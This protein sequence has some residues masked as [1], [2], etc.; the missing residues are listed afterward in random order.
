MK[1]ILLLCLFS[2]PAWADVQEKFSYIVVNSNNAVIFQTT[3]PILVGSPNQATD[4]AKAAQDLAKYLASNPSNFSTRITNTATGNYFDQSSNGTGTCSSST[5]QILGSD[6]SCLSVTPTAPL[7]ATSMASTSSSSK[8]MDVVSN[9]VMAPATQTRSQREHQKDRP[10]QQFILAV[11]DLKYE[12]AEFMNTNNKGNIGGFSASGSYDISK[13]WT[14]GVVVPY[15]HM[16]FNTFDAD[17]TGT[18]LYVKNTLKLPS[19]FELSTAVNGNYIYTSTQFQAQFPAP[20]ATT[21]LNTFGGGFSTRLKFDRLENNFIPAA[22]FSWQYNQ[23]NSGAVDN[24]QYL[25]KFG[26][27]LGYRLLDNATIQVSGNW[28]SDL[29]QYQQLQRGINYYDVGLEGAWIISDTWQLRGGYKKILGLTNYS[30]D[31]FYLGSNYKF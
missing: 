2:S 28:S 11:A 26:P 21:A 25:V 23:D 6:S 4:T 30:S 1:K 12:H 5:G 3:P 10:L 19:N 22:A 9:T 14:V 17:R 16:A 18:I 20:S 15:D 27:S 31:S 24:H 29:T 13:N 8:V 7:S